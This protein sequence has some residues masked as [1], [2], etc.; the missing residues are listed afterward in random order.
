M[1]TSGGTLLGGR[2]VH[3]QPREGHRTGI[4]PVLLAA[5]VPARA[6]QLVMEGGTGS[7]AGL[8]CLAC[9]VPG[10]RGIGIEWQAEMAD[11]ARRNVAA[12]AA[13][14]RIEVVT[15]DLLAWRAAAPLDHAFANPPWHCT[16]GTSSPDPSKEA[17]K[18]AV[19]DGVG[20]WA[21]AL[22]ACLRHGGTLTLVVPPARLTECLDAASAGGCGSTIIYPLWPRSGREA[23]LMLFRATKGG[24]GPCRLV[25]GLVLHE[26]DGF[27]GEAEALL[28]DGLA[29]DLG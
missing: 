6:G 16:H 27:S 21:M 9:R 7:G 23:K 15:V 20:G 28:R 12:N 17:A 25:P 18:R 14:G 22:A 1:E 3:M 29:L 4:E 24:G 13:D 19:A 11:L 26:A 5:C 2:V 10:M 8:L